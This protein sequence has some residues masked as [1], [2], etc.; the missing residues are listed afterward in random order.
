MA[1]TALSAFMAG[2]EWFHEFYGAGIDMEND[3]ALV[4]VFDAKF[5][6]AE[7]DGAL[8]SHAYCG[9]LDERESFLGWD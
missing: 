8:R 3:E 4:A 7:M 5:A 6:E 1:K 9:L 2:S